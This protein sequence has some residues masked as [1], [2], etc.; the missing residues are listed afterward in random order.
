[1][2]L[3]RSSTDVRSY[4]E[5]FEQ[6]GVPCVVRAGP[7]LFSQPEVLLLIAALAISAGIDEFYGAG[8]NPKSLPNRINQV[9]SCAPKPL[10]VLRAAAQALRLAKLSFPNIAED[11]LLAA[12][13]L[14]QRRIKGTTAITAKEVASLRSNELREFLIK[15]KPLRRVFPQQI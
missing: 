9:L 15:S 11:R 10:Q 14:I 3:V 2:V 12:S 1:A 4:M 5:I 13:A 6:A 7:D 8:F